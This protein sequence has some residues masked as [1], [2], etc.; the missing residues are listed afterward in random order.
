[1]ST[2]RYK[3]KGLFS[4]KSAKYFCFIRII[5]EDKLLICW[6]EKEVK[7]HRIKNCLLIIFFTLQGGII[8]L[9]WNLRKNIHAQYVWT[10][11]MGKLYL[12]FAG[13]TSTVTVFRVGSTT[14]V[15]FVDTI[16]NLQWFLSANNATSQMVYGFVCCAVVACV[17]ELLMI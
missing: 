4:D 5:K 2:T 9:E 6:E 17:V 10:N 8:L 11:S 14:P 7:K 16:S 13:I 3:L 12:S 15:L 1:M